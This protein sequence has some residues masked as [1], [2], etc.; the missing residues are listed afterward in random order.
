MGELIKYLII[1]AV[2]VSL[3]KYWYIIIPLLFISICIAHWGKYNCIIINQDYDNL[4]GY[5]FEQYCADVLRK[6]H[7]FDVRVTKS[8]GDFGIDILAS[9]D[10]LHYAIQC[11][12]YSSKVG[13]HAVQEVYSG[14]DYYG[15]D[16]AIVLTN[17]YFTPAAIKTAKQLNVYLWDKKILDGLVRKASKESDIE[18]QNDKRSE[19][20][21]QKFSS[22]NEV[23]QISEPY[24]IEPNIS[25]CTNFTPINSN[26][27]IKETSTMYDLEKGIYPA[28]EY[29]IGE[30]IPIGQY[31]VTQ[32]NSSISASISIYK[33]YATYLKDEDNTLSY[34]IF[35]ADY[36]L[37]LRIS[38][39]LLLVENADL[40]KIN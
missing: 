11:K 32:R 1:L 28:G 29:I 34:K 15:A 18:I 12:K 27:S 30:D 35:T 7:F 39:N 16:V 25:Q 20:V 5:E 6:N 22:L 23:Q 38:G 19:D 4:N 21:P 9:K 14:K 3:F 40:Q 24:N 17:S 37:T 8:S 33:D 13:N 2:V 10:G 31:I 26:E 36:H